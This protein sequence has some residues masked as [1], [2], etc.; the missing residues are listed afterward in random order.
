[1]QSD[2]NKLFNP[3]KEVSGGEFL[4]ILYNT[5]KTKPQLEEGVSKE[6]GINNWIKENKLLCEECIEFN[7]EGPISRENLA[8]VLYLYAQA[9]GFDVAVGEETNILSYEDAFDILPCNISAM[10]Y[11]AGAQIINGKT[12]STL[13]PGDNATRGEVA[14]IME[15]FLKYNTPVK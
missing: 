1:M 7:P 15:R 12:L 4:N 9:K 5:D 13:N 2:E 10:Q 8:S 11:T 3:D 14:L 6:E